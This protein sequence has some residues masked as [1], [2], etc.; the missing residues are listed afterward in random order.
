MKPTEKETKVITAVF[1]WQL[2]AIFAIGV[3]GAFVFAK[4]KPSFPS[5]QPRMRVNRSASMTLST[6]WTKVDFSG[7]STVN[8][9][10]FDYDP[11][12]SGNRLVYWDTTNKIF[13]F[14]NTQ[15]V[16]YD[17]IFSG[18]VSATLLSTPVMARLRITI[19]NGGGAGIDI[20]YPNSEADGYVD[21]CT[22]AYIAHTD[23]AQ[24]LP[25]YIGQATRTNGFY[26]EA[27]ISN[28]SL[29]TITL[30]NCNLLIQSTT[31]Q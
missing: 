24:P 3:V 16:N 11:M 5:M 14:Y 29:G 7:T 18:A 26:I 31:A 21:L 6:T 9:N 1:I 22:A 19:P 28:T 10:T 15:D 30:D 12:G 8:V 2:I 23:F 13:K 17:V 27:A 25:V 4:S 20:H